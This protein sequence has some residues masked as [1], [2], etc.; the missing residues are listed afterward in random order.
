MHGE[1]PGCTVLEEMHPVSALN[2]FV[3][4]DTAVSNP[5]QFKNCLLVLGFNGGKF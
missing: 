5:V 4:S 2:K 3:L 1:Y